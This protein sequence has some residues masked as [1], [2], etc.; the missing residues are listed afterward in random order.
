MNH[1]TQTI[2]VEHSYHLLRQMNTAA[3]VPAVPNMRLFPQAVFLMPMRKCLHQKPCHLKNTG[4][5]K[6]MIKIQ[7]IQ[8]AKDRDKLARH[9]KISLLLFYTG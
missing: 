9:G 6:K 5:S 4:L 7:M 8:Q 3:N 1:F 2:Y